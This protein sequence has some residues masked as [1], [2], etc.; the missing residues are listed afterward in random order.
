MR[1]VDL[2]SF[3]K[4][5]RALKTLML[6]HWLHETVSVKECPEVIDKPKGG[7]TAHL[8]GLMRKHVFPFIS[9]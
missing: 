8:S 7:I 4:H 1:D 9:T 3:I 2:H 6:F 5:S